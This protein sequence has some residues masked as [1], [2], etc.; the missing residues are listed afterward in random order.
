M[1]SSQYPACSEAETEQGVLCI[2]A[3]ALDTGFEV[4]LQAF[5]WEWNLDE[6]TCQNRSFA[7][8]ALKFT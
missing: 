3:T 8:T 6:G 2:C 7:Y 1:S 4:Q 5:D